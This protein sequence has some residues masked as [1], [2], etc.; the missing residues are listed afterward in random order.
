MNLAFE[1]I[2]NGTIQCGERNQMTL[3]IC[4]GFIRIHIQ[5]VSNP[6]HFLLHSFPVPVPIHINEQHL[7]DI[8]QHVQNLA[9]TYVHHNQMSIFIE[10]DFY[11]LLPADL[12]EHPAN[13]Y[14][15]FLT[16]DFPSYSITADISN[17]NEIHAVFI[18][19]FPEV[20][21]HIIKPFQ[22]HTSTH[23]PVDNLLR[24]LLRFQYPFP[25]AL[26]RIKPIYVDV[27]ITYQ[28]QLLLLNRYSYMLETEL[29]YF[30][31]QAVKSAGLKCH[32]THVLIT[33]ELRFEPQLITFLLTQFFSLRL[34]H[35]PH[36][37]HSDLQYQLFDVLCHTFES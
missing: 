36:I 17:I 25:V 18:Y 15:K 1:T 8:I 35:C 29:Q 5:S 24:F 3:F 23:T 4:P 26:V 30:I 14:L 20:Y 34:L 7:N 11:T 13:T 21:S 6:E 2:T 33:G 32:E 28:G 9:D 19:S 37:P 12:Y 22:Q 27:I 10:P 16:Q 31:Q